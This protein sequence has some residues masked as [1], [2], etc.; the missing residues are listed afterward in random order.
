MKQQASL[1]NDASHAGG[2]DLLTTSEAANL[3]RLSVPT[4][5]RLRGTGEGPPYLKLGSGRT[6]R[7]VY[8]KRDVE[9]WLSSK[10]RTSTEESVRDE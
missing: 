6:S 5:E 2:N 1:Q 4:M 10:R 3:L 8:E 9:A 7:V